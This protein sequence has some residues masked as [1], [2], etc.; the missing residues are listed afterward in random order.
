MKKNGRK[1]AGRKENLINAQGNT[2]RITKK[3][4]RQIC[5]IT[6]P[7]DPEWR[8]VLKN[9]SYVLEINGHRVALY[10][11]IK[12]ALFGLLI[13]TRNQPRTWM[14]FMYS[15]YAKRAELHPVLDEDLE[16]LGM[17]FTD[18]ENDPSYTLYRRLW[19]QVSKYK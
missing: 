5:N 4:I 16:K 12:E 11:S 1:Q 13:H 8:W 10:D 14:P 6:Y 19:N 7:K 3:L 17:K 18:L 2:N 9:A 15:F